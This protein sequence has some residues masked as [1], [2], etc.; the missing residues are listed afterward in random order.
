M[1]IAITNYFP[2]LLVES[3]MESLLSNRGWCRAGANVSND[4]RGK[5]YCSYQ[6]SPR[7]APA[8]DTPEWT[9]TRSS[10]VCRGPRLMKSL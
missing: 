4:A 6:V 3:K 5:E 7:P 8:D 2:V 1:N 9:T 10:K